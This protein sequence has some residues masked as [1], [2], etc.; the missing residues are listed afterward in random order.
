MNGYKCFWNGKELDVYAQSQYG[1]Q[2]HATGEFQKIA[3]RKKVKTYDIEVMLCE[4]NGEQY[5][6]STGSI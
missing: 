1:A 5:Y 2:I 6:H 3:G 4:V